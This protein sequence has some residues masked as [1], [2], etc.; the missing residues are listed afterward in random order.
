MPHSERCA[1]PLLLCQ[2]ENTTGGHHAVAAQ[3]DT[4]VVQRCVS[5]KNCH[6]QFGASFGIHCH[7]GFLHAAKTD[8]ALDGNQRTEMFLRQLP[9]GFHQHV[10]HLG[11]LLRIAKK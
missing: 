8:F 3:N 7:A 9:G 2:R 11:A 6:Q 1:Q 10:N 5:K 4:A